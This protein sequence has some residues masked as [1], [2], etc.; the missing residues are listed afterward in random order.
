MDA[1]YERLRTAWTDARSGQGALLHVVGP[2][3][4]GKSALLDRLLEDVGGPGAPG[5]V[6]RLGFGDRQRLPGGEHDPLEDLIVRLAEGVRAIETGGEAPPGEAARVPWLLPGADFVTAAQAVAR[7]PAVAGGRR[8]PRVKPHLDLLLEVTRTHPVLLALDDTQLASERAQLLLGQLARRLAETEDFRL[9]VVTTEGRAAGD[10]TTLAPW[11]PEPTDPLRVPAAS[12]AQIERR[13]AGRLA[14]WGEPELDYLDAVVLLSAGNPRACDLLLAHSERAGAFRVGGPVADA[15]LGLRAGVS[16][17]TALV[18]GA[19][20]ALTPALADDLAEAAVAGPALT[21]GLMVRLWGVPEARAIER[22]D[23]LVQTGRL[24]FEGA[25]RW[26]FFSPALCAAEV[27]CLEP[28]RLRG[29]HVRVA[30][31]L[32]AAAREGL[33]QPVRMHLDVTENWS[34]DRRRD[35]LLR[36]QLDM[37]WDAAWHFARAGMHAR[38]AAAAIT[39]TERLFETTAWPAFHGR[40]G[41]RS[42]RERRHA[43]DRTLSEAGAQ[44]DRA[45][46]G[47]RIEAGARPDTDLL[48]IDIRLRA[49]RA[50]FRGLMGDFRS[51][52]ALVESA[53]AQARHLPPTGLPVRLQALRVRVE[54]GY[55]SGD[56]NDGRA[57]MLA[58][59]EALDGAPRDLAVN[60]CAWLADIVGR[61]EWVGLHDRIYPFLLEK[62]RSL[63]AHREAI[64]ARVER[65]TAAEQPEGVVAEALLAEAMEEARLRGERAWLAELLAQH[66]AE[67]LVREVDHHYDSLSGEFYTPDLDQPPP[68]E[69]A[70]QSLKS[71]VR[72]PVELLQR[73]ENLAEE[74]G[75]NVAH[76]RVLTTA[77]SV[78]YDTRERLFELLDRWMPQIEDAKGRP[79]P[80]LAEVEDLLMRGAFNEKRL[81]TLTGNVVQLAETLGL[82]QVLADTL[83]EALSRDLPGFAAQSEAFGEMARQAYIRLGDA[84]GMLTLGL[85]ALHRADQA[86]LPLDAGLDAALATLEAHGEELAPEQRAFV[87]LRLGSWLV[88]I[89]GRVDQGAAQLEQAFR[90]YD[91]VGDVE[92]MQSVAETLR[93]VYRVKGDLGRYRMLR[94][95]FRLLED[96]TPG[97]DPLNLEFRIDH[98]LSLARQETD[99]VRAIEMV[100]RAIQLFARL[101]DGNTRVDECFVEI[102]K[103]CRRRAEESQSEQGFFDWLRRSLEAVRTAAAINAELGNHLRVFEESHELFDDLLGMGA[104]EEYLQAR[105]ESR[106]QAFKL[107]HV[108]E[109]LSLFDEHLQLDPEGG[110][111]R[112]R[113]PELR[114]FYEALARYLAGIGAP[115]HARSLQRDFIQFLSGLGEEDLVRYHEKFRPFS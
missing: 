92:Q 16:A 10:E 104:Y 82:D 72:R 70:E 53:V 15:Q 44:L 77:L 41:R 36:T 9:L 87:Q 91:L 89:P 35:R 81:E 65:L 63:D 18:A 54:L 42:D 59:I 102:S 93:E 3:G 32:E 56:H 12:P 83:Y 58:L 43:I 86:G 85:L 68:E 57:A 27:A 67:L 7:L 33:E 111:D 90:L 55:Q 75:D 109:L 48:V 106:N 25:D 22:L 97:V 73:A 5:A 64:K 79:P 100:E 6:V 66:A 24:A 80:R 8:P 47:A 107:G 34:D 88:K 62:L 99:D 26:R 108:G 17:L 14:A 23:A 76:L 61:L 112:E 74:A 39:H 101:P 46:A 51:A 4:S 37:L 11:L 95:R 28:D 40:H 110:F 114:G 78:R 105:A 45:F 113:L 20:T 1:L 84:Y 29:L 30:E 13:A 49:A 21:T 98:V 50:R 31:A 94:E 60:T 103:I 38:A 19:P 52:R 2:F 71:R 115:E 96:R 69:G